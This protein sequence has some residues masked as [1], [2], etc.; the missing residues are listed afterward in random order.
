MSTPSHQPIDP[1]PSNLSPNTAP[2]GV[3]L[4]GIVAVFGFIAYQGPSLWDEI[5]ALLRERSAARQSAVVGYVGISPNPSAA[6]PPG[7]WFRIEGP[8][9][10][11]WAGWHAEQGHRWFTIEPDDLDRNLLSES[12]GRDLFQGINQPLAEVG[13]GPISARIPGH[14]EVEA[15]RIDGRHCAYPVIVL[16]KVLVINDE[17]DGKPLLILHTKP[18]ATGSSVFETVLDGQRLQMGFA[19]YFYNDEPLL[20][21]RSSEGL[22][23]EQEEGLVSLSGPNR[24]RI[25]KRLGRMQRF[26]WDDWSQQHTDG[27]VVVGSDRPLLSAAL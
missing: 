15:M 5:N 26:R 27:R 14:H 6:L 21:D 3:L 8:H 20:Y 2:R 12:V 4:C 11:L 9:V 7:N 25:L 22:W 23:V 19:G 16:D 18:P 10:R 13:G 17:V 24:G 1:S